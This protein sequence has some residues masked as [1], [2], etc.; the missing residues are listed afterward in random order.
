M[1]GGIKA[2]EERNTA[3]DAYHSTP[4]VTD[5]MLESSA[6][7]SCVNGFKKEKDVFKNI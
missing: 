2:Q 1:P 7:Q 6:E 3:D 5:R 4:P